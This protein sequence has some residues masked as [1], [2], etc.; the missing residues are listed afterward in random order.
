MKKQSSSSVQIFS[1][2]QKDMFEKS[3]EEMLEEKAG[4]R[5]AEVYGKDLSV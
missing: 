1:E 5:I 2:Q 3:Y 4:Q